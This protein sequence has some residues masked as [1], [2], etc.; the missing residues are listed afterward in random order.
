MIRFA[1]PQCQKGFQVDDKA[2]GK[3][4]KCPTCGAAF[5]VP[6]A[7][8]SPMPSPVAPLRAPKGIAA[9]TETSDEYGPASEP[10]AHK[11][12]DFWDTLP[13]PNTQVSTPMP[14]RL[15]PTLSQASRQSRSGRRK[16]RS[17]IY[18][19]IGGVLLVGITIGATL[20]ATGTLS[21]LNSA[22]TSAAQIPSAPIPSTNAQEQKG[23][24]AKVNLA[25]FDPVHRAVIELRAAQDVGMNREKFQGLLQQF[26]TEV[27]MAT[28][29]VQSP[30]EKKI[31]D[32]YQRVLEIYKDSGKIWDVKVSIP[33]LKYNADK[34][35]DMIGGISMDAINNHFDFLQA[36]TDGI[37]LDLYPKG[38]SGLDEIVTRYSIPVKKEEEYR[39]R[40]QN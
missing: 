12:D 23:D 19:A 22:D 10:A 8:Q 30:S 37:P 5:S 24:K 39:R 1:C 16:G 6:T 26:S 27:I 17:L 13:A 4:T 20:W 3:K 31:A 9:S 2:A 29:K 15:A 33:S 34:Y 32:G 40:C 7:Q 14:S 21:K 18:I 38:N 36:L 11:Q 28:E 35:A 25:I